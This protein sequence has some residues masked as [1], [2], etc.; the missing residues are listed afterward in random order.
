[1]QR[2][3]DDITIPVA[4]KLDEVNYPKYGLAK[5]SSAAGVMQGHR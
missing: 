3:A 1:M 5:L 4:M 2:S